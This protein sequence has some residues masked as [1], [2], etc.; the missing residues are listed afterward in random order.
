MH[1]FFSKRMGDISEADTPLA[2]T[3]WGGPKNAASQSADLSPIGAFY[4]LMPGDDLK[5]NLF[6]KVAEDMTNAIKHLRYLLIYAG[7][8]HEFSDT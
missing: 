4:Y 7:F 5:T 6:A 3:I 1:V 2:L 8:D